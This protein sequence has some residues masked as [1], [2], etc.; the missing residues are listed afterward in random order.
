M[1]NADTLCRKY[2]K[3]I[4]VFTNYLM[5]TL[6]II[7]YICIFQEKAGQDVLSPSRLNPTHRS[8]QLAD[9]SLERSD[10]DD[11]VPLSCHILVTFVYSEQLQKQHVIDID[12]PLQ[13]PRRTRRG[14]QVCEYCHD[15]FIGT[16]CGVY[17]QE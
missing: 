15:S 7:I 5:C 11:L 4:H 3:Q 1:H 2:A 12:Y 13:I 9:F 16:K 17:C 6:H 10:S 14:S 8:E